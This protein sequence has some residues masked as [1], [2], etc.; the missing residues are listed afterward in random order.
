MLQAELEAALRA[1]LKDS[2]PSAVRQDRQQAVQVCWKSLCRMTGSRCIRFPRMHWLGGVQDFILQAG[3]RRAQQLA[4]LIDS[5]AQSFSTL[6][7]SLA[8]NGRGLQG[9]FA[10]CQRVR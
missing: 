9:E 3:L 7:D 8:A 4:C 10:C 5:Y 2:K 1:L 6:A